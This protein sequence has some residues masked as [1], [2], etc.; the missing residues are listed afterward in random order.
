MVVNQP[1]FKLY[2]GSS[3]AANELLFQSADKSDELQM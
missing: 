1:L 2:K 3:V